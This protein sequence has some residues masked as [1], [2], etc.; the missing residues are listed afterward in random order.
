MSE[1]AHLVESIRQVLATGTSGIRLDAD[2]LSV[3]PIL[4]WGGFVNRSF[5]ISDVRSTF[6]LKLAS[7][8][9][10][11]R[12]LNQWRTL[13]R[14]LE[15]QYHAPRMVAW[16]EIEDPFF[17]G[18]VFEWIEGSPATSPGGAL[19]RQISVVIKKLHAD[20]GLRTRL[21]E[22]ETNVPS[23]ADAYLNTFHERFVEDL[24]FVADD[25]PPFL[26]PARLDWMRD[27][28]AGLEGVV[29]QSAAFQEP[30]DSPVH[31][32][33]LVRTTRWSMS[34]GGGTSWTGT[35]WHW[36]TPSRT[37]RCSSG[38]LAAVLHRRKKPRC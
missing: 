2:R 24:A 7:D 33:L 9:E 26:D 11:M 25:L 31:G 27:Q 18:P 19:G 17:A 4:N 21:A 34:Q 30:A 16:L 32:D 35:V 8:P 38:L 6:F 3:E 5:R 28:A 10:V 22:A 20:V 23:C 13:A 37:G 1:I 36:E 12:G 14:V 15:E 29:R